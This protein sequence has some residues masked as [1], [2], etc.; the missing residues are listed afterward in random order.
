MLQKAKAARDEHL[1]QI[2]EWKDFVPNLE[3]NNLVLTPWVGGEHSDWE[4]WVKT[5]SR[6]ESLVARGLEGESQQTATCCASRSNSR[7]C[8][9]VRNA[10]PVT[11]KQRVG[12]CGDDRIK[13]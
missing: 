5:K 9:P 13:K 12:F 2:T 3:K 1:V 11:K 6:Q 8:R 4:E 10:L 7:P